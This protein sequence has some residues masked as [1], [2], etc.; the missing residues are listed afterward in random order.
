MIEKLTFDRIYQAREVLKGIIRETPINDTS[1]LADDFE[2]FVKMESLQKTGSF[3]IRGAYFKI[4]NLSDEEKSRGIIAA[5]AGNHAQGVAYTSRK[6][7]IN[8]TIVMPKDAPL[9]KVTNTAKHG[10]KVELFGNTFQEAYYH[11]LEVAKENNLTF[12][13][14]YDDIDVIAGQGTIGLEILDQCPEVDV[15][16]VPVG[17]GGLAAGIAY[18]IK[19]LKPTCKVYGVE[20]KDVNSMKKSIEEK[21]I[22]SI[23]NP[24]TIADGIAVS[25]VGTLTY[26]ICKTYLDG[27]IEVDDEATSVAI[28][29]LMERS[30]IVSEGAGAIAVAAALSNQVNLK[31]KKVVSVLSGGNI[32]V[33]LL[34]RL[35]DVALRNL[36]RKVEI[37][38]TIQD[39]PGELAHLL[40]IISNTGANIIK[41]SH[42]RLSKR[43][44]IGS[45]AVNIELETLNHNHIDRI[46]NLLEEQGFL[47][48]II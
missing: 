29:T 48:E 9:Q 16:F 3:K 11:A 36:G 8:A 30:K 32:D 27:I 21:E 18:A 41:I 6:L 23:S 40:E 14:P 12:I 37:S 2:L 17:G 31:G 22:V 26:D 44:K 15:V 20:A 10:A 13:E 4:F 1:R 33:T 45:S 39:K 28:L 47:V 43:V 46:V 38:T 5:S 24:K 34:S 25:K 42:N 35:I 19:T 7:G